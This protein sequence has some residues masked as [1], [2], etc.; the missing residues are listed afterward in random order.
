VG[1]VDPQGANQVHDFAPP[2]A[3]SGLF[4]TVLIPNDVVTVD[5]ASGTAAMQVQSLEM[6]DSYTIP[7]NLAGGP[8]VPATVGFD[9]TWSVPTSVASLINAE[10]GYTGTFLEVTSA[11]QWSA[12]TADFA[13]VSDPLEASTSRFGLIGFEAN[14][15]FFAEAGDL[16]TPVP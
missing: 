2:I 3:P 14:G 1:S 8:A 12:Q 9:L 6:L 16:S 7:N 15:V 5:L 11:L 13:F 10:Q 4:W